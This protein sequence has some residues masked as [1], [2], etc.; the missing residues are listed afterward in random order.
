MLQSPARIV[1]KGISI[2]AR[3]R[4]GHV[5]RK[6]RQSTLQIPECWCTCVN[7]RNQ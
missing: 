1:K 2:T 7:K 3:P 4:Q 5:K 6:K